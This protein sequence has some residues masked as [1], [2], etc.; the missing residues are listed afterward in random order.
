MPPLPSSVFSSYFPNR[1]L[2][3]TCDLVTV[4]PLGTGEVSTRS[5]SQTLQFGQFA[6]AVIWSSLM[7]RSGTEGL[8]PPFSRADAAATSSAAAHLRHTSFGRHHPQLVGLARHAEEVTGAGVDGAVDR[9]E[10]HLHAHHAQEHDRCGGG[11][12]RSLMKKPSP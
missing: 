8:S 4:I 12:R 3:R 10:V 1:D 2:V 5:A 9:I 6:K 11:P 7:R